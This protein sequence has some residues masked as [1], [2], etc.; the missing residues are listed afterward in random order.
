[1]VT[2]NH[3]ASAIRTAAESTADGETTIAS[4]IHAVAGIGPITLSNGIP[5]YRAEPDQPM[6][7]PLISPAITPSAYPVSN[8]TSECHVLSKSSARSLTM[9]CSTV[10]GLGKYGSGSQSGRNPAV[11]ISHA[12]N[13]STA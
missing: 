4:G 10:A 1:M 5:Q 2:G 8:R 11:M 6:Q 13:S 3:T 7:T 9:L 12:H